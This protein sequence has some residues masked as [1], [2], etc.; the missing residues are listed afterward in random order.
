MYNEDNSAES[1]QLLSDLFDESGSGKLKVGRKRF[2][3][4]Y[5]TSL[6][7]LDELEEKGLISSDGEKYS[8]PL[9]SLLVIEKFNY[10]ANEVLL[11]CS[12]VYPSLRN[13]YLQNP[14]G[15]LKLEDFEKHVDLDE[16]QVN[17]A[18]NYLSNLPVFDSI[19]WDV[20][21]VVTGFSISENILRMGKFGDVLEEHRLRKM[22]ISKR[23]VQ[24]KEVAVPLENVHVKSK[25]YVDVLRI[26]QLRKISSDQFD[27]MKVIRIC[28][29]LNSSYELGN[30]LSVASLVRMLLD[31]IPPIF[32]KRSFKEV[33]NS[34][35]SKSVKNT[36]L[37]LENSSRH[38]SDSVLH[39]HV[40]AR[41]SLPNAITVNFS[42]DLDVLL[43]E[44][45]RSM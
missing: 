32:E 34:V 39:Q 41:E 42:N 4:S 40:R 9:V 43:G 26:E 17:L 28:E 1:I 33:A 38:I 25:A 14:G 8:V 35:A 3:A 6:D 37:N 23:S 2:R 29:E 27:L 19:G 12:L 44:I 21:G 7:L 13:L 10:R 45:V 22:E 36:F 24:N 20:Q 11:I 15:S 5:S 16:S 31:H 30:Y 18:V